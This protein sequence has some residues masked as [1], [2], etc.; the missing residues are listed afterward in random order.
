MLRRVG[1]AFWN[2][3]LSLEMRSSL[4][5]V[6]PTFAQSRSN[7]HRSY[8][9]RRLEAV[10]TGCRRFREYGHAPLASLENWCSSTA[11]LEY[12]GKGAAR[13][14]SASRNPISRGCHG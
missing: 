8:Q 6:Q 10:P 1:S 7:Q 11:T 4:Q 2:Q 3:V 13:P 12:P 9:T 14:C 5:F